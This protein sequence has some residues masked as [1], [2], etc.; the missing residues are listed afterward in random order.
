MT[1]NETGMPANKASPEE[2]EPLV[3]GR[4][5]G[6]LPDL[7]N[8]SLADL[9]TGDRT[10]LDNALSRILDEIRSNNTVISSWSSFADR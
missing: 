4:V 6:G 9:R 5:G 7:T 1:G 3:D 10:A 8:V 2:A